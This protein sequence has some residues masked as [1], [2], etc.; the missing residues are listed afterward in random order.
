MVR[1]KPTESADAYRPAAR[2]TLRPRRAALLPWEPAHGERPV[3]NSR[4]R[5]RG[6]SV[7]TVPFAVTVHG[8]AADRGTAGVVRLTKRG[9]ATRERIVAAAADLMYEQGVG[10]TS[11]GDVMAASGTGPSQMYHYFADKDALV[12]E[13]ITTQIQRM[14]TSQR[15][16][17]ARVDSLSGLQRWRAAEVV[18]ARTR[19]GH[20][21]P[22]GSLASE[23]SCQSEQARAALVA[24]FATWQ[25]FLVDAL[26][27][28]RAAGALADDADLSKL[29]AGLLAALE[30]G[31]LLTQITREPEWLEIAL[32]AAM[33]QVTAGARA[34]VQ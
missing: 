21:C 2:P 18:V 23:L 33:A 19:R 1:R 3:D 4:M 26:V 16:L 20:G 28:I 5:I 11:L 31:L 25:T 30:G 12:D 34:V 7:W 10:K 17:L 14:L 32:D 29:A 8:V 27:R 9:A 24:G 13:V 15:V 22:L 6:F